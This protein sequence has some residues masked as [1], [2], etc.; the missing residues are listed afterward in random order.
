[1]I[2]ENKK[3]IDIGWWCLL[4]CLTLGILL[5]VAAILRGT[6]HT[7]HSDDAIA[8]LL[9]KEQ[10]IS[11]QLI[12][13]DWAYAYEYWVLSLNLLIIPFLKL[14]GQMLLSRELAV[15]LQFIL[16]EIVLYRLLRRLAG[17][18]NALLGCILVMAPLSFLQMEHFY[19]QATYATSIG[20]SFVLLLL[21][22]GFF[23]EAL[24]DGEA[25]AGKKQEWKREMF[26]GVPFCVLIVALGC[27]GTRI[28]GTVLLPI[29]G[30]LG[31]LVWMDADYSLFEIMK[32]RRLLVKAGMFM[33][34]I[35]LGI[36]AG[37]R[38]LLLGQTQGTQDMAIS[39][40]SDFFANLSAFFTSFLQAYGCFEA[41]LLMTSTGILGVFKLLLALFCGLVVP[42]ALL[43]NFK[44]L[45]KMQRFFTAYSV[46]SFFVI[47]YMMVFC[48]LKNA[49]YFLPVYANNGILTCLFV[50]YYKGRLGRLLNW[51]VAGFLIPVALLSCIVYAKYNY[52]SVDLWAGFDT[53]DLGLLQYLENE[54]L[55]YGYS[56]FFNAQC[57]TVASNGEVEI[58]SVNEEYRWSEEEER[59]IAAICHPSHARYW[60]SSK[61]WYHEDYHPGESFILTR[62]EFLGEMSGAFVEN[63]ERVLTYNEYTILVYE[64]NLANCVWE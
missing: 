12:P 5:L 6:L 26:Y 4:F 53:V 62:T 38:L 23:K 40:A 54:G 33:A 3:K 47:F 58:V 36:M 43:R 2:G 28:L 49:Y 27:G 19:F 56:D 20:W 52:A 48:G 24:V 7:F 1:M 30:S 29:A 31:I 63:A 16:V 34:A 64:H 25:G 32:K 45:S 22:S 57:Y 15:I 13:A 59:Y 37:N 18:K 11:G 21:A 10:I 50:D 17:K 60:L 41:D 39:R 51:L 42:T 35:I 9:A 8:V 44:N 55:T 61:R 46:L 14:T